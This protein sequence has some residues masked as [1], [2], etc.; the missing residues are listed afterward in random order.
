MTIH[1][2]RLLFIGAFVLA[3]SACGFHLRDAL[4]LPPDLG[5]VRVVARDPYSPLA[6]S[7]TNSL[8]R[9]GA[10]MAG[11]N[12]PDAAVLTSTEFLR[13][14]CFSLVENRRDHSGEI[15][16]AFD[17]VRTRRTSDGSG[18]SLS[19]GYRRNLVPPG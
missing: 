4:K 15:G 13:D 7:L 9:A 18:P 11:E 2:F 19:S 5:Q 1:P 17:P 6:Q 10:N 3:T 8:E 14:H 12:A 16:L